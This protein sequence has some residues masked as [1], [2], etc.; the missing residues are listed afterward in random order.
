MPSLSLNQQHKINDMLLTRESMLAAIMVL[1]QIRN[2]VMVVKAALPIDFKG[3]SSCE[4]N[5]AADPEKHVANMLSWWA[6][7]TVVAGLFTGS[8]STASIRVSTNLMEQI[9]RR[10]PG[11]SRRDFKKNPGH[12]CIASACYVPNPIH[13]MHPVY[14]V[15]SLFQLTLIGQGC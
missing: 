12:A 8:E 1:R 10:F 13:L 2:T 15:L 14:P 6:R 9:S 3:A 5:S 4:N 11:D 7:N